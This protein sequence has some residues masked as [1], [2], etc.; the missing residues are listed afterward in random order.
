MVISTPTDHVVSLKHLTLV[1]STISVHGKRHGLVTE[2][3]LRKGDTSSDRNL[4]TDDSV[5]SKE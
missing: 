3:L 5:S 1:G 4:S 2:V